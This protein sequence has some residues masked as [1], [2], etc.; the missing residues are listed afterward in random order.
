MRPK[1]EIPNITMLDYPC[2][3]GPIISDKRILYIP[4]DGIYVNGK[5]KNIQKLAQLDTIVSYVLEGYLD[6]NNKFHIY[7]CMS[8]HDWS[9]KVGIK[10]YEDR[11]S[12]VRWIVNNFLF[13]TN[14][15]IDSYMEIAN[16]TGEFLD[17]Y[18]KMLTSGSKGVIIR[19]INGCYS[20]NEPTSDFIEFKRG[21]KKNE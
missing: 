4:Y 5:K 14:E 6:S 3:V 12:D 8:I 15:F 2:Y 13:N 1:I 19:Y 11:L 7:D 17:I 20:F 18:K 21:L 9:T 16:N 10:S